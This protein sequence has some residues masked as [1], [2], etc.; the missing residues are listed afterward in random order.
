MIDIVTPAVTPAIAA[1][2]YALKADEGMAF[3]RCW[4]HGD[5]DVIRD[6]WPDAPQAVFVATPAPAEPK[7]EQP[8][9]RF[10]GDEKYKLA[11]WTRAEWNVGRWLSAAM[12]DDSVCAEMKRDVNAWFAE[13]EARVQHS[14]ELR[15]R[16]PG[17][18]AAYLEGVEEGRRRERRDSKPE[19]RAARLSD[20]RI[21][22]KT[23]AAFPY[24]VIA[25]MDKQT[26]L[27]LA[28]DI[29]AA[30]NGGSNE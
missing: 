30:N 22:E 9:I 18:K 26:M 24:E 19:Q 13:L 2:E 14:D 16:T 5:F 23:L 11:E 27:D 17:E 28:H 15:S 10:D 6:E 7:G 20:E 29:I 21:W 12:E 8:P 3:L 25:Y 4:L 1:I